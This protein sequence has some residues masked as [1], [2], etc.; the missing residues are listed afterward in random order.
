MIDAS[1]A[2][3]AAPQIADRL[4]YTGYV[5]APP[6]LPE[7]DMP[8]GEVLVSVGGGAAGRAL[9]A[10]AF[11]AISADYGDLESYFRNGL[12]LGPRERA[13]LEARYLES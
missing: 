6:P 9:L 2:F 3:P 1:V 5:T 4:H 8:A 13:D 10:A 12:G 11:D 7:A